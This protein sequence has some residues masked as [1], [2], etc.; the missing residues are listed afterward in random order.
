[1]QD[2]VAI[3]LFIYTG[4]VEYIAQGISQ[5]WLFG[6][7]VF[8]G[9]LLVPFGAFIISYIARYAFAKYQHIEFM[10]PFVLLSILLMG[11][12]SFYFHLS[13]EYGAF[14]LGM[15]FA[16]TKFRHEIGTQIHLFRTVFMAFFLMGI[17][18]HI[19]T[20]VVW[21]DLTWIL[22]VLAGLICIKFI[23]VCFLGRLMKLSWAI[24]CQLAILIA[25]A[26]EFLFMIL[27]S[28]VVVDVIGH[29]L[30][31]ALFGVAF[32]SMVLSPFLYLGMKKIFPVRG[33][34]KKSSSTQ[35]LNIGESHPKVVIAGF[36]ETG[37]TVSRILENNLIPHLIVDY[38]L[39]R[40]Q[41][42]RNKNKAII[43]G[44]IRDH[45]LLNKIGLHEAEVLVIT[46]GYRHA[47]EEV[48][49]MLRSLYPDLKICVQV[50]D[51]RHASYFSGLGAH[52]IVPEVVGAGM[53][54]AS[55]TLKFLG[56]HESCADRMT[57]V[58]NTMPFQAGQVVQA[59]G[60]S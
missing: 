50:R 32:I 56:F 60:D 47:I 20:Y 40:V 51:F 37:E 52:V 15:T 5:P 55:E 3:G 12:G 19:D 30:V 21:R 54:V 34:Y 10:T 46:F 16:E 49:R 9:I 18:V 53:K 59:D 8:L 31:S 2:I 1:L 39:L 7:R 35:E 25:G 13:S 33:S 38:D 22:S 6:G 14:I 41:N 36:G 27:P 44:D 24:S 11:L 29:D 57:S 23:L 45:D 4:I 28:P 26:G 43:Y 48:V 42:Y 58:A 17:G